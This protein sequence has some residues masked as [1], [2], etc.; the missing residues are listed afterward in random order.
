[1]VQRRTAGKRHV[2]PSLDIQPATADRAKQPYCF[3]K[4]QHNTSGRRC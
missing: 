4:E 3:N 1:M 2:S